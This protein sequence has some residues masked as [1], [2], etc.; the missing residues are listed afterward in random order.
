[1]RSRYALIA[2]ASAGLLLSSYAVSLGAQAIPPAV[3]NAVADMNRPQADKDR[4]AARHPE[5]MM[6][7]SGVKSG[8]KVIELVPGGGYVTRL[9]SKIVGPTGHVYAANLP[10]FNERFKTGVLAVTGSPSYSN[11]T[12]IEMPFE[13]L[14]APEPVDVVWTSENYHDFQNMG[15]FKTDTAAMDKAV[16][17]ALKPGGLYVITDYA[18]AAGSG[19]RD[20]QALHRIDPDVIKREV[21]AAGFRFESESN[22]LA[23]P[24]DNLTGHSAQGSAQVFYR[25]RKP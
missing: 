19:L 17:A 10:S 2:I 25:F 5:A 12:V 23:N 16:F 14:K 3:S 22:V 13:Q 21:T 24:G 7:A 4:D 6:A 9:I 20:T 8:D 11:V 18:A 1:M 15:M